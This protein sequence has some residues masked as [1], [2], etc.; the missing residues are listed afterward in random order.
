MRKIAVLVV[1]VYILSLA[2]TAVASAESIWQQMYDNIQ[3][4]GKSSTSSQ[5]KS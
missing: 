1:S 4:W 2:V 3:D 5:K